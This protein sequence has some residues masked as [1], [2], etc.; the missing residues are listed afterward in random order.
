M[1][2]TREEIRTAA[3]DAVCLGLTAFAPTIIAQL[4]SLSEADAL[5]GLYDFHLAEPGELDCYRYVI[6]PQCGTESTAGVDRST[7]PGAFVRC[8]CEQTGDV[9]EYW[10]FR[11]CGSL[12]LP[13]ERWHKVEPT[14]RIRPSALAER[15]LV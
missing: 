12:A 10:M 8:L 2:A 14:P 1:S 13:V 11:A 9:P 5:D 3:E 6:C 4:G 7:P 15:V